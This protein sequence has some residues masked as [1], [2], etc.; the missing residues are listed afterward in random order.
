MLRLNKVTLQDGMDAAG[1]AIL[2]SAGTLI[3][4][5][6]VFKNNKAENL[7]GAIRSSGI[8]DIDGC[9]FEN[10][11][12]GSDGGAIYKD[13][14]S[15][16]EATL[17][18]NGALFKDNKAGTDPGSQTNGG[19]GGALYF[20]T[21]IAN[22]TG[23]AFLGNSAKSGSSS[24]SGGGAIHNNG[25][26][27]ITA[28]AFSNNKVEGDTWHGGAIFNNSS[29]ILSVNFSH[30][31]DTP[32]PLTLPPFLNLTGGNKAE[33]DNAIGGAVYNFGVANIV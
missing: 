9:D 14:G 16:L 13:S 4:E 20:T 26:L 31:G 21:S 19:V 5:A 29:G 28:S 2:Q 25:A 7:G 8:I 17:T 22:I 12:A 27:N 15:S 3:C 32:L 24:N 18:I 1:G 11:E 30:F 33:G 6:S 10:N 23:S